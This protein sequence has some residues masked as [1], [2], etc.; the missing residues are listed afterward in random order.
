MRRTISIVLM[1]SGKII[2]PQ[3]VRPLRLEKLHLAHQGFNQSE[4]KV[5][6]LV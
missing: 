2:I 6:Q 1:T 5:R 3:N 4:A